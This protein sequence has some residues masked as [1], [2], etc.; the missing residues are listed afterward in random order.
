AHF[1]GNI[2]LAIKFDEVD[3]AAMRAAFDILKEEGQILMD[4]CEV[5][6]SK[7]FGV[8]IDKFGVKWNICQN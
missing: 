4:I 8:L 6:W 7:C 5:P 1:N 2:M 3:A